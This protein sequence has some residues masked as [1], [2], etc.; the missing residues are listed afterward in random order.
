M[1]PRHGQCV[2]DQA[3]LLVGLHAPAHHLA[4][5]QLSHRSQV[6]PVF[7]SRNRGNVPALQ[8]VW[9]LGVEAALDQV[10]RDRQAVFAVGGHHEFAFGPGLD[11]VLFR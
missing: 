8:P 9:R 2:I 7:I 3:G 10:G 1:E 11:A 6:H 5:E 4:A